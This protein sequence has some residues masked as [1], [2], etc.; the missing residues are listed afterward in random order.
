MKKTYQIAIIAATL[1][2]VSSACGFLSKNAARVN[3]LS[4][5][6]SSV[7]TQVMP[8]LQAQLTEVGPT[9]QAQMEN[10]PTEAANAQGSFT[11][12]SAAPE[13]VLG[14]IFDRMLSLKSYREDV[15]TYKEENSTGTMK[16]EIVNPDK[17]H[18][19]IDTGSNQLEMVMIGTDFYMKTGETWIKGAMP[20]DFQ[21]YGLYFTKYLKDI[22]DI[23]VVGPDTLDGKPT[24]VV[25]FSLTMDKIDSTS[26]IWVGLL[27]GYIYKLESDSVLDNVKYHTT[28]TVYDF[29]KDMTIEAPQVK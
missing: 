24:I 29:N 11:D 18:G 14:K 25:Q 22:K 12:F 7:Q 8:S 13:T 5:A 3:E 2:M 21:Q 1:L 16:F 9:L 20:M 17:M 23:K 19:V 4:T 15:E 27:D 28:A 26:K 10:L 6:V